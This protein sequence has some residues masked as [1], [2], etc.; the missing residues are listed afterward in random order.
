[1]LFMSRRPLCQALAQ[2]NAE[3]ARL[4][5]ARGAYPDF[6]S[7]TF[8]RAQRDYLMR[9]RLLQAALGILQNV[10]WF[11]CLSVFLSVIC[12]FT[13]FLVVCVCMCLCVCVCVCM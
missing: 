8:T 1:M 6:E 13:L 9:V 2:G 3:L 10:C 11:V 4:L 12:L 7:G 5:I